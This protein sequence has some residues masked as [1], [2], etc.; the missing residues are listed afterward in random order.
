MCQ[1]DRTEGNVINVVICNVGRASFDNAADII[2]DLLA[3]QQGLYCIQ[4]VASWPG[5]F[6]LECNHKGW[7]AVHKADTPSAILVPMDWATSDGPS[8]CAGIRQ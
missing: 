3:V 6:E 8:R 7:V 5:N 4:E 1:A 2:D